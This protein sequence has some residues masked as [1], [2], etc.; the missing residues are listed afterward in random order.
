MARNSDDVPMKQILIIDD[1]TKIINT[2]RAV[3]QSAGYQVRAAMNGRK[4]V[5]AAL[6]EK[7]DLIISDVWMPLGV[8]FSVAQRLEGLGLGDIPIIFLTGG[9]EDG[10]RDAAEE[11]G[12]FAFIEKPFDIVH[13][14]KTVARALSRDA[15]AVANDNGGA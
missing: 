9:T 1:D 5:E 11:A 7:P 13:L 15:E 4:G 12:A 6:K 3:L 14:L 10:L 2:L 8:G